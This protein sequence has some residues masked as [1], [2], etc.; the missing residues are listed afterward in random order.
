[1][2]VGYGRENLREGK[3]ADLQDRS[4]HIAYAIL[5]TRCVVRSDGIQSAA[6]RAAL[7][8]PEDPKS[9]HLERLENSNVRRLWRLINAL[10]KVRQGGLEKKN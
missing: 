3:A 6:N 7:M 9:L 4:R 2:F 1:M 5:A 10:G 8:A